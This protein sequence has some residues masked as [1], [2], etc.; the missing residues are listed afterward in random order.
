MLRSGTAVIFS[1]TVS[2]F[3][4]M[5]GMANY[6]S[7]QNFAPWGGANGVDPW[8][9]INPSVIATGTHTGA[10][11]S[12]VLTDANQN[13]SVNQWAA[14]GYVVVDVTQNGA[15]CQNSAQKQMFG[16]VAANDAHTITLVPSVN[17]GNVQWNNGDAY[18]IYQVYHALDQVGAGAGDLVTDMTWGGANPTNS[19][20][21]NWP[22]QAS[23]PVYQWGNTFN[24]ASNPTIGSTIGGYNVI[25]LGRDY[26]D[27]TVKPGYTPLVYPHPLVSGINY[28][29]SL[30]SPTTYS[31][32]VNGGTGGGNYPAGTAVTITANP[33][34]GQTF[35]SWT[36]DASFL[37]GVGS[38]TTT[39]TMPASA[40]TVTA[41]FVANSSS[42]TN[43]TSSSSGVSSGLIA[44]WALAGNVND[45]VGGNNGTASGLPAYV[46]GPSGGS[47]SAIGLNGTSQYVVTTTLGNFGASCGSGF[48]LTAWVQTTNT[49]DEAIFGSD[50]GNGMCVRLI[51]N[52]AGST[53]AG[54]IEGVVRDSA[55][56]IH[57]CDVYSNSGVTD[58][59][60]HFVVWV[61][62]PAVN[63]GTIYVDGVALNTSALFSAAPA[64]ANLPYPMGLG[65]RSGQSDSFFNGA[66]ADCRVYNRTL[67]AAEVNTLYSNGAVAS[68]SVVLPPSNLQAGPPQ[69]SN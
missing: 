68:T 20:G 66:L 40:V 10:T 31:L 28:T 7:G 58:G 37:A 41:N 8:D 51:L 39:V 9:A 23:D 49:A 57:A 45:Q 1:N 33:V 2:G 15:N 50:G 47:G 38:A 60:W 59:N 29:P 27:N 65:F 55:N 11:G 32:T 54:G 46:T 30:A 22:H 62:N 4:S 64:T 35:A 17:W 3:S 43:S 6:R 69:G 16:A 44:Q 56:S 12:T 26:F 48:T 63:S 36:G 25:Q 67:S 34:S 21:G 19:L 61:D 5:I 13:W 24:G 52:G 53:G 14:N 18:A 42:P